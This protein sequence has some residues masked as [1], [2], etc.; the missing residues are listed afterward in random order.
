MKKAAKLGSSSSRSG[1]AVGIE[2]NS[3]SLIT[4]SGSEAGDDDTEVYV[5]MHRRTSSCP[6]HSVYSVKCLHDLFISKLNRSQSSVARNSLKTDK[7]LLSPPGE[8][9]AAKEAHFLV[10]AAPRLV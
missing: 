1:C 10:A 2:S 7:Y 5:S 4:T 9:H 3:I 6:W 8:R